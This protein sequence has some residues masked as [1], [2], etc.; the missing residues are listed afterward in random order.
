[1]ADIVKTRNTFLNHTLVNASGIVVGQLIY[2]LTMPIMA[3]K[4]TA[5]EFGVYAS[6]VAV[7]G[8]FSCGAALRFDSALPS[9]QAGEMP[10]MYR[11]GLLACAISLLFGVVAV[12]A[13]LHHYL[14]WPISLSA[15]ILAL[16][17]VITGTLQA[18]ISVC[19]A[20]LTWRGQFA[21]T[22]LLRIIQPAC[23]V[24]AATMMVP[25]SL[26]IAF[27][28]GLFAAALCGFA[29][30]W[31]QLLRPAS[32]CVRRVARRYWEHPIISLPVAILDTLALAMPVL[33]IVQNYGDAA[34]G[35]YSQVQRLTAA[36]LIL[37]A[38]AISQVFYKHAADAFRAGRSVR[39]LMWNTVRGLALVGAALVLAVATLGEPLLALFLG[40]GWRTDSGYLMLVLLPAVI[41]MSVSPITSVFAVTRQLKLAALWQVTY[42]ISTWS[43]L[44]YASKQYPLDQ[45][46][47]IIVFNELIL[48]GIY[49]WM[50]DIAGRRMERENNKCAG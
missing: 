12:T 40:A 26:P 37:C 41:R 11:L 33:F 23:F 34:G 46:L 15:P 35:N 42:T 39:P 27:G 47:G 16:L 20:V 2:L 22:T 29:F 49:L 21:Q 44:R 48:Y 9:T 45:L 3:R 30:S 50:A 1:M 18:F 5:A 13:G 17:C 6:L 32:V 38:M 10:S 19:S 14:P 4:Y 28:C 25:G 43:V 31:R 36:P 7:C 8:I 24:A